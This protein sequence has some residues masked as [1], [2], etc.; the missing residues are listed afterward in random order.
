MKLKRLLAIIMVTALVFATFTGCKKDDAS[1]GEGL[2]NKVNEL[3]LT[4]DRVVDMPDW[5]GKKMK[6]VE[7]FAQGTASPYIGKTPTDRTIL[8]EYT[9]IT[10]I[11]W[12]EELSFDNSG[13]APDAKIAKILA[14]NTWPDV[15]YNI[16][17]SLIGRLGEGDYI[18]DLTEYIPKY[19]PNLM[20]IVN[21]NDKAKSQ[22]ERE[23][24]DGK[25]LFIPKPGVRGI[26][27]V[28]DPE[29]S[30]EKYHL[31]PSKILYMYL[32]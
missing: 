26:S 5:T 17:E 18:W 30:E 25:F 19:M 28:N 11:S 12:D 16:E 29:F 10:G 15:G 2:S 27:M 9:R 23:Q 32:N 8:D 22:F 4:V 1:S 7:W 24:I 20:A 21:L 31:V 14:T 6:L 3:A 13:F